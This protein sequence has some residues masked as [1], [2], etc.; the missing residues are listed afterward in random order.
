MMKK[1]NIFSVLVGG[2]A[3]D[4][5]RE[6]AANLSRLL[7][8]VGFEVIQTVEY[9]SLIRGGHN[10]AR[11]TFS[12]DKIHSDYEALDILV[13]LNKETVDLHFKE[14]K[15]D[16][17]VI[18]DC[19]KQDKKIINLPLCAY[20]KEMGAPPILRTAAALGAICWILNLDLE[21]LN[22]IFKTVFKD[23]AEANIKLSV[24]G[25]ENFKNR[26]ITQIKLPKPKKIIRKLVDGNEAFAE[27]LIKAGLENYFAYPMTPSSS[28][29]HF[30]AGKAHEYKIKVA[31][32]ENEIAVINM[33]LGSAYAGKRT[34]TASTG[35]GF[36][37][38]L[39]A[40]AMA[41]MEELP[42]VV[43]DSQRAGTSTGVATRTGQ[44]DL[45]FVRNLPGEFPQIVLAPGDQEEAY[46]LGGLSLNL[47][48]Q[49]Q[50]PVVVLLDK[51]LSENMSA[52]Q[53][54]DKKIKIISSKPSKAGKKYQRYEFT[55]DGISP[56]AFPGDKDAVVKVCS[57]EHDEKGYI[58]DSSEITKAMCEKRFAK[59]KGIVKELAKHEMIK[60]YG[61]TKS[62]NTLVFFGSTKG[63][64]LEA[65]K[66]IKKPV[67]AVQILCLE[68]LD[69][70]Q[71]KKILKESNRIID[72]ENNYTGQLANLIREKTGIEVCKKI[73]RYDSFPFEPLSLADTINKIL[74]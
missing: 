42:I 59:I 50:T 17:L 36:A 35:G 43:A 19:E 22:K 40:M 25:Y 6:A 56:L 27:G 51:L 24:K 54:D 53:L 48:W 8:N 11:V 46:L 47:A 32:P 16:G 33:A 66:Y 65:L 57:Y 64:I 18:F 60:V 69:T 61:D 15:K 52:C 73:L 45:A 55:D 62:K 5:A 38:M 30:L 9:P 70:A 72:I 68:P 41:G 14:L 10:F 67:R 12:D 26:K 63:A 21:E 29:L 74:K 23:K 3:G 28:I 44:G 13:A 39:E 1:Q 49:F 7:T 20:A 31:Q 37:L 58:T 4:G 71:L 2:A 34:A